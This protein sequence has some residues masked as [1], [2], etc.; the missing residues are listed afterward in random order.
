[1]ITTPTIDPAIAVAR[2][3]AG[4]PATTTTMPMSRWYAM[5]ASIVSGVCAPGSVHL[6]TAGSNGSK[7]RDPGHLVGGLT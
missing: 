6:G 5:D 3:V 2:P 4:R 1:M 7:R